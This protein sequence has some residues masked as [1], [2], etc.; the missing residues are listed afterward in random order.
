MS[1]KL[2][3]GITGIFAVAVVFL[4]GLAWSEAA[5]AAAPAPP[6]PVPPAVTIET[7]C[8]KWVVNANG[9]NAQFQDKGSSQEY[10]DAKTPSFF[11]SVKKGGKEFTPSAVAFE[12][13][14]ITVEFG[15]A[16]VRAIL[17]VKTEKRYFTLDVL[18]VTGDPDEA[19]L[20]NVPLTLKGKLEEPFACSA[21]ALNLQTDVPTMP[22]P[23]PKLHASCYR[24]FGL[25]GAKV[26]I[27][28][29]PQAQL[30]DVMKEVVSAAD[31]LPKTNI[32]G[33][34]ALDGELNRGS[35]VF[36][37]GDISESTVDNWIAF[38]KTLG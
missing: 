25:Q 22:G 5:P 6:A 27:L 3:P 15:E 28:A 14:R 37:F 10:L 35:Y 19:V 20:I 16:G 32:G 9:Q 17:R 34:W 11:A 21:L 33:P 29:C 4:S 8:V 36:D 13:G 26:A 38:V 24:K 1:G 23:N 7:D 30:R 12:A 18:S 31:E 2:A